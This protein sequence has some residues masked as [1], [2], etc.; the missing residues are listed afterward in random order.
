[1]NSPCAPRRP[2]V[3]ALPAPPQFLLP[4]PGVAL[5]APPSPP[6]PRLRSPSGVHLLLRTA[7]AIPSP[8]TFLRHRLHN[9][10]HTPPPRLPTA[11]QC[12]PHNLAP[13]PGAA[14]P[15][16]S[17]ASLPVTCPRCSC[18]TLPVHAQHPHSPLV[19]RCCHAL[20]WHLGGCPCAVVSGPGWA[21][22]SVDCSNV[23]GTRFVFAGF[24]L[25]QTG[26]TDRRLVRVPVW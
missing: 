1:M 7:P 6:S 18:S 26:W 19:L 13:T 12:S 8:R 21:G 17:S 16:R 3:V 24:A 2:G 10:T 4:F 14:H 9:N 5:T 20:W 15:A 22:S 23:V 25:V 11:S